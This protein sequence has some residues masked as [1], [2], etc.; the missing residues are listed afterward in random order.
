V[1]RQ[2]PA[3][4]IGGMGKRLGKLCVLCALIG[5]F[6]LALCAPLRAEEYSQVSHYSAHMFPRGSVY[7]KARIGD[8][9]VQGWDESRVEVEAEKLVQARSEAQARRRYQQIKIEFTS[10]DE[11]VQL[12]TIFPPRRPWRLFRGATNLSVNY[13]IRM[14]ARASLTLKCVDGDVRIR[15]IAGRQ[16]VRVGY[17]DV[18]VV[19][20]SLW[21]LRSLKARSWLGYVQ[22]DLHGEDSAGFGRAVSFWNPSGEQ[23]INVRV[24]FGGVYV[25]RGGD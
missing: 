8:L 1:L 11:Q 10:N 17:G 16:D 7:I 2:V 24:R 14:P 25:Y 22:S 21:G 3:R 19:V 20:P 23:E 5:A 9:Y 12:R 4:I 6:P 15:G 18:E 13:R